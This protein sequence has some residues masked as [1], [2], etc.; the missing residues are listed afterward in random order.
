LDDEGARP[1]AEQSALLVAALVMLV[2]AVVRFGQVTTGNDSAD[3]AGTIT[4]LAAVF[5]LIAT[6]AALRRRSAVC[7]LIAAIGFGVFATEFID[8]VDSG[9]LEAK[10]VRW[11]FFGLLIVYLLVAAALRASRP[12]HSAQFVNAGMLAVLAILETSGVIFGIEESGGS[13]FLPTWWEIV[14]LVAPLLALGYA[15]W[16]RERGPGWTGGVALTIAALAV[17]IPGSSGGSLLGWP[18]ILLVPAVL[19]LVVGIAQPRRT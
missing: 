18:L 5:T 4:W 13:G 2:A 8:W 15:L 17:G 10:G 11:I 7:A 1:T 16:A 6:A 14:V 3:S 9:P 19:A 12:R